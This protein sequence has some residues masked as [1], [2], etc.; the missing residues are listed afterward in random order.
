MALPVVQ[1]EL[2]EYA[3]DE[4]KKEFGVDI[5]VEKVAINPFGGVKL[6]GVL[7]RDHHKDTLAHFNRINTTILSFKKLYEKGHPYFG[8][9]QADQLNFK[10]KQ[11]KGENET[12]L[13]KFVAAF[14]DGK[15]SSGKFRLKIN[16]IALQNSRFRYIDENLKTPK[17]LDFTNLNGQL[18]DFYVKGSDV[19][20]YVYKMSFKDHRGLEM[21]NLTSD[22]TYTKKNILLNELELET[23]NSSFKGKTELRYDRKDFKDFNNKVIFDLDIKEGKISSNDLNFFYPE[24]GK[25]QKFYIDSHIIGTLNDL[26][27]NNLKFND[28]ND[29][30]VVGNLQLKNLFGKDKQEF[31][32]K[33]NFDRLTASQ[34]SVS[35]ILPNLLG[36]NLPKQLQK[37]GKVDLKGDVELTQKW[38]DADVDMFSKLGH[39]IADFKLDKMDDIERATYVGNFQLDNF[40][41]GAFIDERDLGK[42]SVSLDVDGTGFSKK[43]LNTKMKGSIQQ[44]RYNGYTYQNV[45]VD[46]TMKMP[47]FKGYFDSRDPNLKMTFNGLVDLSKK[48][49]EY[50]FNAEIEYAD[51]RKTNLYT[52]DSKSILSGNINM[53][54]KGNTL[55]DLAGIIDLENIFYS[56]QKDDYYFDN[57]YITSTFDSDNVRTITLNSSDMIDGKVVGKYQTKQI[58]KILE[59]AVGSLYANYS[60]HQLSKNQ[61][62]EFDFTVYNKILE[63][64]YPDVSISEN[65]HVK[66]KINADEGLFQFDFKSPLVNVFENRFS[67]IKIDIDNKNPLYNAY[68]ELDSINTK[69][70]KVSEFSLINLTLNDTLFA[71]TEFKGGAKGEDKFDLNL[72]HTIDKDKQS[73]VGFKKSDIT[74]KNYQWYIN[75]KETNGNIV[76]FDKGFKNFKFRELKLSHND[77]F[78]DFNGVMNGSTYKDFNFN[79]NDVDISK[80]TPEIRNLTLGGKLNGELKYKQDNEIHEPSTSLT[81]DSLQVNEIDLGDL[82]LEVSGD[83]SFRKFNVDATILHQDEETFFTT[84]IVEFINGKPML[85]L[86]AGFQNFNI[87]PVGGFLTGILDNVRGFASGRANIVGP[88]EDPEIDGVLYLNNAGLKVP[89]V[90]VD[91]DFDKN[92]IIDIT[93]SKF[94]FRNIDISDV[95]EETKGILSGNI[96]HEKLGNWEMD[97]K[98]TSDKLLV[99][100]TKDSDDAYYY[101]K[102]YFDGYATIEGPIEALEINAVGKSAKG[103]SVKIPVN[104][105]E[106]VGD[107]NSVHFTT[108]EEKYGTTKSDGKQ[109]KTYQGIDLNF[110]FDITPDAE[111]EVILNRETGHSMKGTGNGS[112]FMNINTLGKFQMNGNYIV[113]KG[114]Y[115]FKY[116]S[117]ID[118]KFT[119]KKGGTIDWDGDPLGAKLNLEGVYSTTANPGVLVDNASFNKKVPTQVTI[120]ITGELNAPQ[121]DFNIN[122]P[123]VSSVL[124]SE[125][126]YSLQDKDLRQRQAFALMA[127]GSFVTPTNSA[128]YGTFLETASNIFGEVLSDG[129]NK[130]DFSVGYDPADRKNDISGRAVVKLTTQVTDKITINGSAAV[131]V[132]GVNQSYVVGNVEVEMRLNPDG[133]LTAHVFN[134]ENDLNYNNVGQNIGYTQ[135]IGLSYS[136]DFDDFKELFHKLFKAQKDKD[137]SKNPIDEVPD[138]DMDPALLN[139]I[140]ETK[141]RQIKEEG[142]EQKRVPQ[143]ED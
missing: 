80:V 16:S 122:F 57:A 110:D 46:G 105:S 67:G 39:V 64:F 91:Y 21:K 77:Q 74:F 106:S 86:D 43:Y 97:L 15:K 33:G 84:G 94:I 60:P 63:V 143:I 93:E 141:K 98:V 55:D 68:I 108:P 44:F 26:K 83:Q 28:L 96:S 3:T 23:A 38:I 41:L 56:N 119:V 71:R 73:V 13:D 19:T 103:T 133:T 49:K 6:K 18:D 29:N 113:E 118:K 78:I 101:G 129:E 47:Y 112:M 88:L 50:D 126:D 85:S 34:A 52:K 116:G 12:N 100:D 76:T 14:D 5:S 115:L 25:N 11:Y 130:L 66:G 102:A 37:L 120:A 137:A 134:K 22:F 27:F 131:P 90:N 45:L 62:L 104:D 7:V 81:I 117:L 128:W 111:I 99:L 135:G 127:T 30:E 109:V 69:K 35:K 75:E 53:K 79:F 89:Y 59:N 123:T 61:F 136:V 72:F 82:K 114:E 139:F 124:K 4:L 17:V 132:D 140:E 32:L 1:T 125:I 142:K 70:Y 20:A 36:K 31:Y 51:L 8:D 87:K 24:F 107:N 40:D 54:A 138:S 65:T 9:L 2:G 10:I 92:S 121:S 58:R 95:N 42:T 48:K